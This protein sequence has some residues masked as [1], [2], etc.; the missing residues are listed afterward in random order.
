MY[1]QTFKA[2]ISKRCIRPVAKDTC[3]L[4]DVCKREANSRSDVMAL[5][6]MKLS[7]VNIRGF[8]TASDVGTFSEM[9]KANEKFKTRLI[10]LKVV[11]S[12]LF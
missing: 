2:S 11:I 9:F 3:F 7:R 4:R 8:H 10:T 5:D 12:S 1:P 6:G